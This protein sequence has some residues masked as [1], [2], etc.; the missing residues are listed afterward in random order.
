MNSIML[1]TTPILLFWAILII[2]LRKFMWEII[3]FCD[4]Y[5]M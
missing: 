2:F 1:T 5:V 4:T 3:L